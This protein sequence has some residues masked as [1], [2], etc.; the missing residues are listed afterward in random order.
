MTDDGWILYEHSSPA[1]YR[2][3]EKY[4]VEWRHFQG[5]KQSELFQCRLSEF[6]FGQA[7]Q[8]T[9]LQ[10]RPTGIWKEFAGPKVETYIEKHFGGMEAAANNTDPLSG[11]SSGNGRALGALFGARSW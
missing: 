6:G 10:W 1:Q 8:V 4:P 2:D 9:D 3:G 11:G 5:G 7:S